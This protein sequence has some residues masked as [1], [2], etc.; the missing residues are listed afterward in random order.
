MNSE[1]RT[2]EAEVITD[3]VCK[4]DRKRPKSMTRRNPTVFSQHHRNMSL[5]N[6]SSG[7]RNGGRRTF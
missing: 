7:R 1:S 3:S 6:R 4:Q 5:N 2:E